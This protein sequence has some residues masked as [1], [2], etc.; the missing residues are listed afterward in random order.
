MMTNHPTQNLLYNTSKINNLYKSAHITILARKTT[1]LT[2]ALCRDFKPQ[3]GMTEKPEPRETRNTYG[4]NIR[5]KTN[6]NRLKIVQ[7]HS[8]IVQILLF[9]AGGGVLE[10]ATEMKSKS[11]RR[12]SKVRPL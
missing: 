12:G 10:L 8:K 5:T 2:K 6:E 3:C 9:A 1:L 4:K 11:A 7:K